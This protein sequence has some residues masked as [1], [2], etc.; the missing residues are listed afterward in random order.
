VMSIVTD[1]SKEFFGN[2]LSLWNEF[3]TLCKYLCLHK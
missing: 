3:W 2:D 1:C